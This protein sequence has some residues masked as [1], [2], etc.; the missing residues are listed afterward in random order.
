MNIFMPIIL[1][2]GISN[3]VGGLFT[4]GLYDRAVRGKQMPII[5]G[6]IPDENR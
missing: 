4:R 5:K 6:K 1:T 3:N 2:I